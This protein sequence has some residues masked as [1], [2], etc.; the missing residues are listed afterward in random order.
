ML[1]PITAGE[2]YRGLNAV[3][4]INRGLRG[5]WKQAKKWAEK[6]QKPK[7]VSNITYCKT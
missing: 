7:T 3:K 1:G 2:K 6:P 5:P 4:G